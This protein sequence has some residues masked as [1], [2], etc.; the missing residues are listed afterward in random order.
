MAGSKSKKKI[1]I[2]FDSEVAEWLDSVIEQA[3]LLNV[4]VNRSQ[5]VN[6][7]LKKI[8]RKATVEKVARLLSKELQ[9][10]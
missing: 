8:M 5:L 10:L 6:F 1:G 2:C 4:E 9:R 3:E 7:L